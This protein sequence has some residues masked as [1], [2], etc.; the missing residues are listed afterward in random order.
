MC[1]YY[2]PLT[3]VSSCDSGFDEKLMTF[4]QPCVHK[5]FWEWEMLHMDKFQPQAALKLVYISVIM[6]LASQRCHE[7]SLAS[8]KAFLFANYHT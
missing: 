2:K 4:S 7:G 3:K 1:K 5:E 6:T 8:H